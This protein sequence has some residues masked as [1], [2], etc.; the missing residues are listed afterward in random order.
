MTRK[1][2]RIKSWYYLFSAVS[3]GLWYYLFFGFLGKKHPYS[4]QV[5]RRIFFHFFSFFESEGGIITKSAQKM[6]SDY[7]MIRARI[8][9]LSLIRSHLGFVGGG[10]V[11]CNPEG[12]FF[13]W[14][15]ELSPTL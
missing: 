8:S 1:D 6:V 10:L 13:L 9:L 4:S 12:E 14:S 3:L 5:Q 15:F 7:R 2:C 11:V